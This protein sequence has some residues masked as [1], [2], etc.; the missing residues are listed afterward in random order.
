M[1]TILLTLSGFPLNFHNSSTLLLELIFI[2]EVGLDKKSSFVKTAL[3]A[4]TEELSKLGDKNLE[5]LSKNEL[6]IF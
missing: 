3:I 5:S 6:P 2:V 4:D 1:R